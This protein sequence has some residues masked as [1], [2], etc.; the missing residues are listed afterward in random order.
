[1]SIFRFGVCMRTAKLACLLKCIIH[2][3]S[4]LLTVILEC[5]GLLQS[6]CVAAIGHLSFTVPR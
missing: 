1:M 4:L 5:C 6:G 2:N 3:S